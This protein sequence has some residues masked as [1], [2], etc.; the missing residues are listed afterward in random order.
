LAESYEDKEDVIVAKIDATLNELPHTKVR[1]FPTI[2]LYKKETNEAVEYNGESKSFMSFCI[3]VCVCVCVS[4]EPNL[5]EPNLVKPNI[6]EPNSV[7]PNLVEPNLVEPSLVEP[8]LV[9]PNLNSLL[10]CIDLSH[11]NLKG[12]SNNM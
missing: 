4:V 10:T 8:Y 9:K 12:H 5:V 6:V 11:L 7:E 2:K 3:S 1:S